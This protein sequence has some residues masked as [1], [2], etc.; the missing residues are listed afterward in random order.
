ALYSGAPGVVLFLLELHHATGRP[1]YLAEARAGA[2][3]IVARLADQRETGLYTGIAGSG[4]VLTEVYRA[5]N[6]PRYLNAARRTVQILS[7]R[8]FPSPS[9]AAA[10]WNDVT[11][12]IGG[13]A[14]IGLFLL[15]AG[16]RLDPAAV[17]LAVRAADH[18][19][20]I[21]VADQGGLRWAMDPKFP[22]LMP[23]F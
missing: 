1:E 7:A 18:L 3:E 19:L 11:D 23:N 9:G 14:G 22:R 2:D 5:T 17:R 15:Y 16:E 20:E 10:A 6:D 12:I 21:G 4:F 8:A 13:S